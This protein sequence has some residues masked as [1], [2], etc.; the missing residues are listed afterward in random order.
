LALPAIVSIAANLAITE[1]GAGSGVNK[2]YADVLATCGL[3]G[4]LATRFCGL[5]TCFG[6]TTVTLGSVALGLVCDIT[7]LVRLHSNAA[8][9]VA[10]TE[11]ATKLD[12]IF[13]ARS[14][15]KPDANAVAS[16]NRRKV[17]L[18]SVRCIS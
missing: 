7:A 16:S 2:R 13:I 1:P 10:A 4:G 12:D 5:A 11:V 9:S 14:L 17:S 15:P 3:C 8:E 6:A 18:E